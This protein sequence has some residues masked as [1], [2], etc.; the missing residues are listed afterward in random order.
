M[1][2]NVLFIAYA[3]VRIAAISGAVFLFYFGMVWQPIL[4]LVSSLL[5]R[6]SVNK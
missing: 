4:V 5:M 1:K 6:F 3:L 2:I